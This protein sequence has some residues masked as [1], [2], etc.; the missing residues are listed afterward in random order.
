MARIDRAAGLA[1]TDITVS[2]I[3]QRDG[4]FLC[5]DEQTSLGSVINLPG[6]HIDTGETPDQAIVREFMEETCWVF[7][8]TGFIGA[9]LWYDD[10]RQRQ[11][12]RL[13]YCGD[14]I[15]HDASARRDP[16]VTHVAWRERDELLEQS[17]RLRAPVVLHSIDDYLTG[18][19]QRIAIPNPGDAQRLLDELRPIVR[20]L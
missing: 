7:R 12:V 19:R 14:A 11:Y 10:H 8:P 1:D 9:Y 18:Q 16:V 4:R 6:G 5:I 3:A 13:V 17:H 20:Q 2:G 15:E